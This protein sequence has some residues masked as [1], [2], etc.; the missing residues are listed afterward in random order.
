M[1]KSLELISVLESTMTNIAYIK[2][3][4]IFLNTKIIDNDLFD[5]SINYG[6]IL[7]D[8]NGV[9]FILYK[10]INSS[11]KEEFMVNPQDKLFIKSADYNQDNPDTFSGKAVVL[12]I[13]NSIE[14]VINNFPEGEFKL[15]KIVNNPNN[16]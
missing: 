12:H 3:T 9:G 8:F 15:F 11:V 1:N 7:V 16:S 13:A 2:D 6:F 14:E 4:N 5:S 10:E